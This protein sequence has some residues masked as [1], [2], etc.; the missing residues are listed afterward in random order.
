MRW[1][2]IDLWTLLLVIGVVVVAA[3]SIWEMIFPSEQPT[4]DYG[5]GVKSYELP[6][7]DPDGVKS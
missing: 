4:Y 2:L 5:A 7:P 3:G 6:P 1:L